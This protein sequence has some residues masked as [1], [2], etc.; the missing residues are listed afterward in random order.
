MVRWFCLEDGLLSHDGEEADE[1]GDGG[2]DDFPRLAGAE[3][4]VALEQFAHV[5]TQ[6]SHQFVLLNL[7]DC[8][9]ITVWNHS[10][11]CCKN[12]DFYCKDFLN[13]NNE[14]GLIFS[15]FSL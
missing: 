12:T 5:Q 8:R 7:M 10:A 2:D 3:L 14:S 15:I 9:R 11:P 13:F 1:E 6:V 4:A